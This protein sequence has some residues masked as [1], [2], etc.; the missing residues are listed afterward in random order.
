M[1]KRYFT[2]N[3]CDSHIGTVEASNISELVSGITDA[4]NS[5]YDSNN[6]QFDVN[7]NIEDCIHGNI[8]EIRVNI[9]D[10]YN[11]LIT[12]QETQIF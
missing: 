2:T 11:E 4:L 6:C 3:T 7:F 12:I 9:D 5:H 1:K 10:E 8:K